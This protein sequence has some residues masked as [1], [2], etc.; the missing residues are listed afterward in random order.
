MHYKI[1]KPNIIKVAVIGSYRTDWPLTYA[2]IM[3]MPLNR[4]ILMTYEK[5]KTIAGNSVILR[6]FQST[7]RNHFAYAAE[8]RSEE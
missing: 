6:I 4:V 7:C 2:Q 1:E 5:S 3:V 8:S